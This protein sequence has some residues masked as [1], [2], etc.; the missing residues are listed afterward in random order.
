MSAKSKAE[1]MRRLRKERRE[2]GLVSFSI[3]GI[4]PAQKKQ[5]EQL[6][7]SFSSDA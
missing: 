3:S 6:A 5:L 1:L 4:T 7:A 2:K